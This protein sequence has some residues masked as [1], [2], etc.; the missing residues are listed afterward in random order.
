MRSV[1]EEEEESV[2]TSGEKDEK[3]QIKDLGHFFSPPS[4][5]GLLDTS[6][7]VRVYKHKCQ[8]MAN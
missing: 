4:T 5:K 6:P 3:K 1:E 7:A 8:R 2:F